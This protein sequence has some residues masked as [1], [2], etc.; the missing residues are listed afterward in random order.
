M[1]KIPT[2]FMFDLPVEL[3]ILIHMFM[4]CR[5]RRSANQ[6]LATAFDTFLN[7]RL[8]PVSFFCTSVNFVLRLVLFCVSALVG[9]FVFPDFG[10]NRVNLGVTE[11]LSFVSNV[12]PFDFDIAFALAWAS[13]FLTSTLILFLSL[14]QREAFFRRCCFLF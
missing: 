8:A 9:P 5:L 14:D 2:Y 6:A 12:P 13:I 3:I 1:I 7:Q 11:F 10:L 4:L